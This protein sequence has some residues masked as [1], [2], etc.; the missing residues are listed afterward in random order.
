MKKLLTKL[1]KRKRKPSCP[2]TI[3]YALLQANL[4]DSWHLEK[5]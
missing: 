1:L 5:Q 4:D 2:V 3:K